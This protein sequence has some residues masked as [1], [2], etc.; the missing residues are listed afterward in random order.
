MPFLQCLSYELLEE[1]ISEFIY[2]AIFLPINS[3]TPSPT[4]PSIH[5]PTH[6]CTYLHTHP[7]IY[8]APTTCPSL[9]PSTHPLIHPSI[10]PPYTFSS[11]C[12]SLYLPIHPPTH[13]HLLTHPFYTASNYPLT[14][15]FSHMSICPSIHLPTNSFTAVYSMIHPLPVLVSSIH[16]PTYPCIHQSISPSTQSFA[17]HSSTCLLTQPHI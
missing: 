4:Y 15:I 12:Q 10:H 3:S 8:H 6:P 16:P 14:S 13:A 11:I 1:R 5:L 7:P 17:H 2:P 9:F